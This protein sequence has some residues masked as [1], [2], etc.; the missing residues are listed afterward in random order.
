[1]AFLRSTE[2][3]KEINLL[4]EESDFELRSNKKLRK[5]NQY[6]LQPV[7]NINGTVTVV[8]SC[9]NANAVYITF[10]G[11]GAVELWP[12]QEGFLI[13]LEKE[14][15]EE[16]RKRFR[17]M[18]ETKYGFAFKNGGHSAL[19]GET[20]RNM[21]L[22][23]R[24]I[25]QIFK[26]FREADFQLNMV[27][28]NIP[29]H[30]VHSSRLGTAVL[31][32]GRLGITVGIENLKHEH[33]YANTIIVLFD[34]SDN[35][36]I[37]NLSEIETL[38]DLSNTSKLHTVPIADARQV[39]IEQYGVSFAEEWHMNEAPVFDFCGIPYDPDYWFLNH[40]DEDWKE[41]N[42]S[43][44]DLVYG[45]FLAEK[46]LHA[47]EPDDTILDA[48]FIIEDDSAFGMTVDDWDDVDIEIE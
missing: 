19:V 41:F 43:D 38:D 48:G 25:P 22:H 31:P 27:N 26:V 17:N 1:M 32:D 20:G 45:Y 11:N 2:I 30:S 12:R 6:K 46:T 33:S 47:I 8:A 5:V 10:Y 15:P 24:I 34:G 21:L 16:I 23:P 44:M 28:C 35:V 13:D 3:L 39:L 29:T 36:G 7:F 4:F 14:T 9:G 40:P 18:L 42:A 37:C